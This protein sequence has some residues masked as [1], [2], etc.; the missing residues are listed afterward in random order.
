MSHGDNYIVKKLSSVIIMLG[1]IHARI[2]STPHFQ[3]TV[4]HYT[5]LY[6]YFLFLMLVAVMGLN[7]E[8]LEY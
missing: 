7:L 5:R 4:C 2:G 1:C 3:V 8:P 6:L